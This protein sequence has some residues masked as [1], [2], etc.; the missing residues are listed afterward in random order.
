MVDPSVCN[1][2]TLSI[3]FNDKFSVA[4]ICC[5]YFSSIGFLFGGANVK[6]ARKEKN[7]VCSGQLVYNFLL[8]KGYF[9]FGI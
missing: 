2:C 1:T 9:T 6:V 8:L 5:E 4:A 7:F 3:C